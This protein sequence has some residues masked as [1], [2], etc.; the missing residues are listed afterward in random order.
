MTEDRAA[1]LLASHGIRPTRQRLAIARLVLSSHDHLSADQV[2]ARV[3][4]TSRATVYNTLNVLVERGLV[5]EVMLSAGTVV[6]DPNLERHHHFV[7]EDS[8]RITDLP[9]SAVKVAR[10]AGLPGVEVRSYEVVVRGRR[11]RRAR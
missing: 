10:P 3:S 9:W 8:G 11:R 5:R 1:K 7:D 2:L 4:R 6:Y